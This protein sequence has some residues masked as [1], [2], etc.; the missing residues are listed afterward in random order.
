MI[1]SGAAPRSRRRPLPKPRMP[2]HDDAWLLE[3]IAR[4]DSEAF[5]EFYARYERPAY[6]LARYLTGDES[7]AEDAVQE[8][9]IS[10]WRFAGTYDTRASAT[11]RSWTLRIVAN[12]CS[13]LRRRRAHKQERPIVDSE[14]GFAA[15][16][17]GSPQ[18]EAEREELLVALRSSYG[19][20]AEDDRQLVAMYYGAGMTCDEIAADG[21]MSA[22]TVAYR[23]KKAVESLRVNLTR[24]GFAA[25]A[26]L[27]GAG[28]VGE[29]ITTG[30]DVP[31]GLKASVLERLSGKSSASVAEH[32]RRAGGAAGRSGAAVSLV[33]AVSACAL[34]W[35]AMQPAQS[36]TAPAGT[37]AAAQRQADAALVQPERVRRVWNFEKGPHD[38]LEVAKGS[39][40]WVPADG[41]SSAGMRCVGGETLV[42]LPVKV[43]DDRLWRVS[44]RV[45]FEA[46]ELEKA[47]AWASWQVFAANNRPVSMH[48]RFSARIRSG[49]KIQTTTYLLPG[50][51]VILYY[52]DGDPVDAPS[53]ITVGQRTAHGPERVILVGLNNCRVQEI[54]IQG[55]T[56][57]EIPEPF[58][59]AEQL[60]KEKRLKLM[61]LSPFAEEKSGDERKAE[62]KRSKE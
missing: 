52:L 43:V 60:I 48:A 11:A 19:C 35:Y 8:A 15:E 25:A 26:P 54:E 45:V 50:H 16:G 20:L 62:P 9:M 13:R 59:D 58:R 33:V 39:W 55:V 12:A 49:L 5:A 61:T 17:A 28:D 51:D 38:E 46:G 32:S 27:L 23:I 22:R 57:D 24:T 6:N 10:V 44:F 47:G 36:K 31:A 53:G 30:F 4:K 1:K 7:S 42:R 41:K 37:E 34:A 29:A 3:R 18:Q 40:S 56:R 14:L 2:E 21:V